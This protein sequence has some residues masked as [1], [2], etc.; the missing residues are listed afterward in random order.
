M[1]VMINLSVVNYQN[2]N[3]C[4]EVNSCVN[5]KTIRYNKLKTNSDDWARNI[6]FVFVLLLSISH[7]Q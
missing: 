1:N 7:T 5:N 6:M 3:K 2:T 4:L